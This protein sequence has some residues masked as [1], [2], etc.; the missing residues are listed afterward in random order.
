MLENIKIKKKMKTSPNEGDLK[1]VFRLLWVS[2]AQGI[3][4]SK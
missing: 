1:I 4:L 3:A 2:F